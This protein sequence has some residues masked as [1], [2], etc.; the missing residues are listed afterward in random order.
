MSWRSLKF[1]LFLV[2]DSANLF[3]E[4]L[5][6]NSHELADDEFWVGKNLAMD[7]EVEKQ[8]LYKSCFCC[9]LLDIGVIW[10]LKLGGRLTV[11]QQT[12][13]LFMKVRFLPPQPSFRIRFFAKIRSVAKRRDRGFR[14]NSPR[15]FEILI[16]IYDNPN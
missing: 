16:K 11:G 13:D 3:F 5:S 8:L 12:L 7:C 4:V 9:K 15:V 6:A 2:L 1:N 14:E 10:F